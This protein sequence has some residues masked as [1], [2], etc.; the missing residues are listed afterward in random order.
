MDILPAE[1]AKTLAPARIGNF[2]QT[3]SGGLYWPMDPR[4]EE[5]NILDIAHSLSMQCRYTGH[6]SK[7][8]SVAEHS[9]HVSTIVAPHLALLGLLHDATEAYLTDVARPVKRHLANYKDIEQANW[10]VI[11]RKFGLPAVMPKQ[12]HDADAAMLAAER[13]VLMKPLPEVTAAQWMMGDVQ[14]IPK[15]EICGWYP[16]SGQSMFLERFYEITTGKKGR[17]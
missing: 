11:A 14:P 9:Y 7:F 4:V 5:V 13:A 3:F 1:V 12:I 15:V 6:T 2:M 16:D 8:Y 10:L 17:W